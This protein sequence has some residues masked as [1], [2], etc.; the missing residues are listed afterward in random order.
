MAFTN[1]M[2]I[3][4]INRELFGLTECIEIRHHHHRQKNSEGGASINLICKWFDL[5]GNYNV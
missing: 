1:Y 3:I 4:I 5:S 2:P